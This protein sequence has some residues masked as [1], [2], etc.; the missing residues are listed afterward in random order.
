MWILPL[1][2]SAACLTRDSRY[3]S[4]SMS[5]GE[6]M[7]LPPLLLMASATLFAFSVLPLSLVVT[8]F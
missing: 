8:Y 6:A 2:N 3:L 7:A 5:P 4:S 1:P